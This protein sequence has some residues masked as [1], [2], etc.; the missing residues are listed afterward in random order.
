MDGISLTV[1]AW[2]DSVAGFAIIPYTYAH[3]NLRHAVVGDGVNLEAD[4]LAK[5]VERLL[6]GRRMASASR[7]SM[8]RLVKEGF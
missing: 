1:A 7:I 2:D 8:E 5:Y 6:D 3:T 4:V